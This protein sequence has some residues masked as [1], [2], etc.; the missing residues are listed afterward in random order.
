M[1][2]KFLFLFA[3]AALFAACSSDDPVTPN[4]DETP[5]TSEEEQPTEEVYASSATVTSEDG[6][7]ISVGQ[8]SDAASDTKASDEEN[9]QFGL[10][11]Y[12]GEVLDK[13]D[14]YILKADD[15]AIR[16]NG[17]YQK[18]TI[19]KDAEGQPTNEGIWEDIRIT[20]S[21]SLEVL[22][23]HLE[24]NVWLNDEG[25]SQDVTFEVYLWVENK[26]LKDPATDTYGERFTWDDKWLWVG[27]SYT[28][29]GYGVD[30]TLK[31]DPADRVYDI[32]DLSATVNNYDIRYNV[33]R[34]LSGN[35]TD[36]EG[37]VDTENGLG[38]TP[39]I[40]VSIH[41]TKRDDGLPSKIT[42]VVP[43]SDEEGEE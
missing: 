23:E 4:I 37:N 15:F 26:E 29:D 2:R 33:Y 9:Y 11:I 19:R 14:E 22:I 43:G 10:Q 30:I 17:K 6:L 34:G 8:L 1:K 13:W 18:L 27:G 36:A 28:T 12:S 31:S 38:N 21:N 42:P 5:G 20:R 16:V 35:P 25:K 39:Y 3:A 32:E 24:Q 40:K 7:S 41:I